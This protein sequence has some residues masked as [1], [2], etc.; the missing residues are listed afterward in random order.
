M[1]L[2]S[3]NTVAFGLDLSSSSCKLLQLEKK[4]SGLAVRAYHDMPLPK[5][6]LV[7]DQITDQKAFADLL[8]RALDKCQYGQLST[9]YAVVSL[10]ES[11]SFVRVI[12]I[13][14]MSDNEA[15]A[16]VPVEAESF[17]PLPVDQVYLDWQRLGVTGDKMDVLMVASPREF[18][19][20]YLTALDIA[21]VKTSALEVESQSSLRSLLP[22]GAK[23]T[24]LIVDLD[25]TRSS[26][27]M[28]EGGNLQFTSTVPIGGNNFTENIAKI[29]GVSSVKAE[30]IKKRIGIANTVEYPNIK[31]SLLPVLGSLSAEIKSILKFYGEHSSKTV[32]KI[33]LSGGGAKLKN[34]EAFL[35]PEFVEFPGL[36][37]ELG[38]PW[39]GLP[40]LK[41]P[42]LSPYD[43][44]GFAD[45]IGLAM[46]GLEFKSKA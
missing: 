11:K 41:Q 32:S 28:V 14:I 38:N 35:Q 29:L 30:D 10:P 3:D 36:T 6:L 31:I 26:L 17:I 4:A 43:S 23:D 34:L 18:V 40:G 27:I 16:A 25:A 46:R 9:N 39:L 42:P 44:L 37:V 45:A 5:G 1:G 13:P 33:I 2:L 20:Q 8:K 19:N 22:P 24:V 7:N 12:Q 15:D 21:G